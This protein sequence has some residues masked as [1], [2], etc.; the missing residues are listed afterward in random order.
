M[1]SRGRGARGAGRVVGRGGRGSVAAGRSRGR[2]ATGA[3]PNHADAQPAP[4]SGAP[5]KQP[6]RSSRA[7]RAVCEGSCGDEC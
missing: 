5:R 1:L 6:A 2:N 7:E 3:T 4:A